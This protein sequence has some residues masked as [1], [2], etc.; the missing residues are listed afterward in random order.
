[1]ADADLGRNLVEMAM[2]SAARRPE[3]PCLWAKRDGGWQA[4]SWARVAAESAAIARWLRAH[5]IEPGDRVV[6]LSENRPEWAIADLAIMQAGAITVPAYTTNPPADHAYLLNH[7][8]ARGVICSTPSLARRLLPALAE[9]PTVATVL[10]IEPQPTLPSGPQVGFWDS[11]LAEAAALPPTG[12]EER[13]EKHD[14]ACFIYTSGTGGRP[15][16]VMLTHGNIMS[17]IAGA[18]RLLERI[19]LEDEVFLSFLPLSHAYEHTAGLH[20]P[21][22]I[23]AQIWYAEGVEHLA[24]N[25][26]DARPTILTCVPRLLEVMRERMLQQVERQGGLRAKLFHLALELGRRRYEQGRLLPHLLPADLL[27][28]RLVRR[29]VAERFGGRLKALVSGGAAL[30][31][32]VGLFFVALGVPLLQG[33]G[34]TEASPVISCNPPGACRIDTVGPPLEGVEVRIG[35]D[36]E[37]LVRGPNVMKGYWKDEVATQQALRDGWLHTGDVGA[38]DPDGY[39]RITDRK[40]DILVLSGGE[41]VSPQRVEGL[42]VYQPE[43]AQA[44][45]FGDQRPYVVALIVPDARFAEEFAKRRGWTGGLEEIGEN[46]E[47]RAAIAAAVERANAQLSP[48]ERVRRFAIL[49]RPLTIEEGL[50]TPTLK[51]RR[52]LVLQQ[53]RA[54]LDGLYDTRGS[55]V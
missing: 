28:D 10:F 30:K 24:A 41:N 29:R 15:K 48:F 38:L 51:I 1:M 2:R 17:N 39:L 49:K 16:G 43:I 45:I 18:I 20:F 40:K 54:V 23:G 8:E 4:W 36:G 6:L 27:L 44:V 26:L 13:L 34:Q 9:A 33:Y 53:Y 5:G 7:S 22:A 32:E 50:M 14:V 25:L 19:G 3:A 55:A 52:H 46:A 47:F 37:I 42:L 12:E 31:Y 35:A 11:A 21:L